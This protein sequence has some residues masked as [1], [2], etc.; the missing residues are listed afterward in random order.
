MIFWGT[1]IDPLKAK[2]YEV[3][4]VDNIL[5]VHIE[6]PILASPTTSK[7]LTKPTAHLP[8]DHGTAPGEKTKPAFPSAQPGATST[9]T[10]SSTADEGWFPSMSNL[11][12]SQKWFFVVI[13]I[14]AL[15]GIGMAV[16]FWR[17]RRARM[18]SYSSLPPGEEMSLG[19]LMTGHRSAGVAAPNR[20]TR[21][22]YDAFGEVSDDDED[23]TTHLR[24][25]VSTGIGFNSGFLDD[26]EE[27]SNSVAEATLRYRDEEPGSSHTATKEE[28]RTASPNGSGES[29][30]HASA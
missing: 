25:H 17:R 3:L 24:D 21:E 6:V 11:V 30:E 23:E 8:D 28:S 9:A 19:A 16:F 5:P 1:T 29:W 4:T 26:D 15:F 10:P 2:K 12:S 13:G 14:V 27:P 22:L 20:P 18:A 7:V